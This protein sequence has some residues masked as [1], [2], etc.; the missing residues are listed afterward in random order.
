M[1][2]FSLSKSAAKWAGW[3]TFVK[4]RQYGRA[5]AIGVGAYKNGTAGTLSMI[6]RHAQAHGAG[7]PGGGG[8]RVLLRHD[9]RA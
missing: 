5:C 3:N 7:E 1:V 9:Q 2:Y 8:R 6:Q 4:D